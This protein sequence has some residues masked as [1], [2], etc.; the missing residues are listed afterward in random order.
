MRYVNI[1]LINHMLF[2]YGIHVA[3]LINKCNPRKLTVEQIMALDHTTD[4][5]LD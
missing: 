5:S 4:N 3:W 2:P 1:S